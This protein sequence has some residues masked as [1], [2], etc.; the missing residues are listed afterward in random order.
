MSTPRAEVHSRRWAFHWQAITSPW[1]ET[2]LEGLLAC[3]CR[4]E[5]F[6]PPFPRFIQHRAPAAQFKRQAPQTWH[7]SGGQPLHSP[8]Q[9]HWR[10]GWGD[11][12]YKPLFPWLDSSTVHSAHR[13]TDPL[14]GHQRQA[15]TWGVSQELHTPRSYFGP[16]QVANAIKSRQ[17]KLL[18]TMPGS[19]GIVRLHCHG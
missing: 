12:I 7:Q 4:S 17:F 1:S 13:P 10:P 18:E 8:S 6:G 2:R 3:R 9:V 15:R 5:K 16:F 11:W 19:S 14:M